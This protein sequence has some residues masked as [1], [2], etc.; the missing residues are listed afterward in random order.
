[1]AEPES[2]S[3]EAEH[4]TFHL[5]PPSIWPPALALG[6]A[7]ILTGLIVNPVLLVIG[8]ILG[9]V[10]FV[11]WVRGARREFDELPE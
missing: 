10:S 1:M 9:L 3:E 8:V 2:T 11:L 6:I 5:P 7:F 4:Q